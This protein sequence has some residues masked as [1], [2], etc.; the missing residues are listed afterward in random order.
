MGND[1]EE[2]IKDEDWEYMS[3]FYNEEAPNKVKS[4]E[5]YQQEDFSEI[6]E[7]LKDRDTSNYEPEFAKVLSEVKNVRQL[8]EQGKGLDEIAQLLNLTKEYVS[9]ITMT[10]E[11]YTEDNDFAVAHLVM[12]G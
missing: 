1:F 5:E 10:I 4:L 11:G 2:K 6:E 7:R 3:D 12:I 8:M 9:L